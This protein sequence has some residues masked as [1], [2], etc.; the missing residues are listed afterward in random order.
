MLLITTTPD[1]VRAIFLWDENA[2]RSADMKNELIPGFRS[3]LAQSIEL[4]QKTVLTM[5][6]K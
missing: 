5:A 6:A 2:I 3:A 4:P 1:T